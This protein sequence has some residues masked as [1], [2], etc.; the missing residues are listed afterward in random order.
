[1]ATFKMES[2]VSNNGVQVLN[3]EENKK[4]G[5]DN[6]IPPFRLFSY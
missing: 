6:S 4:G 3:N 5:T 1:M 2:R